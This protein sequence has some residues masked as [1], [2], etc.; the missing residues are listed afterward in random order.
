[1]ADNDSIA[2]PDT[3]T[4]CWRGIGVWGD[5]SCSLLAEHIH[6][7]NC[8]VFARAGKL[9][10]NRESPADYQREWQSALQEVEELTRGAVTNCLVFRIGE[11]WLALPVAV[12][13]EATDAGGIHRI[14]HRNN[15]VLL[16]LT[17]VRGEL[18]LAFSLEKLLGIESAKTSGQSGSRMSKR[19]LVVGESK[20]TFV[21]PVDE[22]HGVA[23]FENDAMEEVPVTV[24]RALSTF[25]RALAPFENGRVGLLD[26]DLLLHSLE[27][28][29]L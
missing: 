9:L 16:G 4:D 6:C 19:M 8:P 20:R 2:E 1:M 11:E 15:Q 22:V 3:S 21:F 23:A 5:G 7:S 18:Q 28:D 10:L 17:N 12:V 29:H 13:R 26:D 24:N 25:T 27:R 14:P